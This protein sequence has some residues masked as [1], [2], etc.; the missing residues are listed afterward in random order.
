VRFRSESVGFEAIFEVVNEWI[1]GIVEG[2]KN[3]KVRAKV[4]ID[5]LGSSTNDRSIFDAAIDNGG[6]KVEVVLK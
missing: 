1:D 2:R 4:S 6:S 3:Q 5:E